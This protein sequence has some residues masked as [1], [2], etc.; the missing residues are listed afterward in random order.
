MLTNDSDVDGDALSTTAFEATTGAGGTV[1]MNGDGTFTYL[2]PTGFE[3][4]DD[5]TY[6]VFDS[7]GVETTA[8]ARVDVIGQSDPTTPDANPYY[9]DGLIYAS[10]YDSWRLNAP[11][12][13]GTGT[14]VTYAFL[15]EAP[16]YYG[17]DHVVS[18]TFTELTDQQKAAARDILGDIESFTNLIFIEV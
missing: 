1:Q 10:D 6:S 15:S 12:D 17:P 16:A 9:V 4:T 8:T 2:A 11:D 5:F 7:N 13:Y 18:T 3:G 14:T